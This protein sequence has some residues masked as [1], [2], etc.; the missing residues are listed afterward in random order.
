MEKDIVFFKSSRSTA[1]PPSACLH[2]LLNFHSITFAHF[3]P[4]VQVFPLPPSHHLRLLPPLR[5]HFLQFFRSKRF[6]VGELLIDNNKASVQDTW[7]RVG[8]T[9]GFEGGDILIELFELDREKGTGWSWKKLW[10][11]SGLSIFFYEWAK[12][13]DWNRSF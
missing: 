1:P 12:Y 13:R 6:S 7:I 11:V 9:D 2:L 10:T 4:D 5:P 3:K 8:I